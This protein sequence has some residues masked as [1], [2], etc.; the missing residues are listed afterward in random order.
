M[1][2]RSG[3]A[4]SSDGS[5]NEA[6][7]KRRGRASSS[8]GPQAVSTG[9]ASHESRGRKRQSVMAALK[10]RR[11]GPNRPFL[12]SSSRRPLNCQAPFRCP[13]SSLRTAIVF[14]PLTNETRAVSEG[15]ATRSSAGASLTATSSPLISSRARSA[16]AVRVSVAS[17]S[18]SACSVVRYQA[19]PDLSPRWTRFIGWYIAVQADVS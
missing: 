12:S 10:S 1:T 3:T 14:S 2:S 5:A 19:Y 18:N 7:K 9:A 16:R 4:S 17:P 6:R 13:M 8:T 11:T 15:S